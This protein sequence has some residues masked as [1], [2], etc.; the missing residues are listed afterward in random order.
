[1]TTGFDIGDFV[2]RD[3]PGTKWHDVESVVAGAAF[4]QCG[5]RLEPT[6]VGN[7]GLVVRKNVPKSDP[8]RCARC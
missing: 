3:E 5:R 4:T 1:M 8:E 2:K 7:I 6:I